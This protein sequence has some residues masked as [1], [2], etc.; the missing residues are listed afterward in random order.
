M[1][2]YLRFEVLKYLV[3]LKPHSLRAG[4]DMG[5]SAYPKAWDSSYFLALFLSSI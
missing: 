2:R 4:N 3:M 5:S 1:P